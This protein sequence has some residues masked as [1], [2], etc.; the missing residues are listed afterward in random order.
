MGLQ[1]VLSVVLNNPVN[2][3]QILG[4]LEASSLSCAVLSKSRESIAELY[5]AKVK[6]TACCTAEY[7]PSPYPPLSLSLID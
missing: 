5:P 4:P 6:V 3:I 1:D 2:Q 7:T